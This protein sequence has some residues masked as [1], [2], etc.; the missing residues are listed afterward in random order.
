MKRKGRIREGGGNGIEV[1]GKRREDYRGE[2]G[3]GVGREG[4]TRE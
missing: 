3:G 2:G 1:G 4:E